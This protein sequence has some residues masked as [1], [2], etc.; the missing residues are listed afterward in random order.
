[1]L[2]IQNLVQQIVAVARTSKNII[3][4]KY[5]FKF[6]VEMEYISKILEHL[7]L[8]DAYMG[9][10][11]RSDMTFFLESDGATAMPPIAW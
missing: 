2:K 7:R 4:F 1:M 8:A 3:I 9:K 11:F 5:K 10:T 6:L